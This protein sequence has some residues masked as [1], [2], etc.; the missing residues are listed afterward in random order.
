MTISTKHFISM[1]V[2]AII[3]CIAAIPAHAQELRNESYVAVGRITANGTV[4][5]SDYKTIGYFDAD[6][7]VRNANY[8]QLGRLADHQVYNASNVRI[9]Y[10]NAGNGY[11][12]VR[13]GE[14]NVLGRVDADGTVRNAAFEIIGYAKGVLADRAACYFFFH[15]FG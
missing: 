6:G 2:V 10:F 1:F 12:E 11:V 3:L 9:G 14:S 13:D 7:T 4:R 15:L 5:N 8:A